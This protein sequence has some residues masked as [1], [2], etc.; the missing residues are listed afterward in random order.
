MSSSHFN[1]VFPTACQP[2]AGDFAPQCHNTVGCLAVM[3]RWFCVAAA[4]WEAMTGDDDSAPVESVLCSLLAMLD[5]RVVPLV[6]P[7]PR[8]ATL[9]ES[10]PPDQACVPR[11]FLDPVCLACHAPCP[12]QSNPAHAA[13]PTVLGGPAW[14]VLEEGLALLVAVVDH[15]SLGTKELLND[16]VRLSSGVESRLEAWLSLAPGKGATTST[17]AVDPIRL[18]C[19]L[20]DS[21]Y[22][23]STISWR[24]RQACLQ[25]LVVLDIT[26]P[27]V[28]LRG[29]GVRCARLTRRV[30][31]IMREHM[32]LLPLCASVGN[33]V[34]AT[35]LD[36]LWSTVG[37]HTC[38]MQVIARRR[39]GSI[40]WATRQT[41]QALGSGDCV[42]AI[43]LA[44]SLE[45]AIPPLC[46]VLTNTR[47]T[48]KDRQSAARLLCFVAGHDQ[49]LA[50]VIGCHMRA[51]PT[52]ELPALTQQLF[53]GLLRREP[54]AVG[55]DMFGDMARSR[56]GTPRHFG[57]PIVDGHPVIH[58][59]VAAVVLRGLQLILHGESSG[60]RQ[61]LWRT[62]SASLAAMPFPALG[63]FLPIGCMEGA[64]CGG[65]P[66]TWTQAFQQQGWRGN[67]FPPLRAD[68][69]ECCGD[70]VMLADC[71][72]LLAVSISSATPHRSIV[73]CVLPSWYY[74]FEQDT[75]SALVGVL[76]HACDTSLA[77]ALWCCAYRWAGL[78]ETGYLTGAVT[79][80]DLRN[81][82]LMQLAA[83][84]L[85]VLPLD[86]ES[87]TRLQRTCQAMGESEWCPRPPASTAASRDALASGRERA[88]QVV[89]LCLSVALG[90]RRGTAFSQCAVAS[91][92]GSTW[93]RETCLAAATSGL[94]A[95]CTRLVAEIVG[96]C[97]F[98]D[99]CNSVVVLMTSLSNVISLR[100]FAPNDQ[101][102][103]LATIALP[104]GDS[105]A[106]RGVL[107]HPMVYTASMCAMTSVMRA[108]RKASP[109]CEA[110]VQ[111]PVA[112]VWGILQGSTASSMDISTFTDFLHATVLL[113]P[114]NE[115]AQQLHGR[116]STE[117]VS[118]AAAVLAAMCTTPTYA[119]RIA[120]GG[121]CLTHVFSVLKATAACGADRCRGDRLGDGSQAPVACAALAEI[122][123]LHDGYSGL[124]P[125]NELL[126]VTIGSTAVSCIRTWVS[127]AAFLSRVTLCAPNGTTG[128]VLRQL[129]RSCVDNDGRNANS[130]PAALPWSHG[131]HLAELYVCDPTRYE[132]SVQRYSPLT[133]CLQVSPR[134]SNPRQSQ[135]A[136]WS[137]CRG[138]C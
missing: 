27:E 132:S 19:E 57:V 18:L 95:T 106:L 133:V 15:A 80:A 38:D 122:A 119:Y 6:A 16:S 35:C 104:E 50:T 83:N 86:S 73:D 43:E 94:L 13:V 134:G 44:L 129:M 29:G 126:H 40:D 102:C 2:T 97:S 88:L 9:D 109:V 92:H 91:A 114:S 33:G 113:P 100:A 66:R 64:S 51:H 101:R 31:R 11:T 12:G 17:R 54:S 76:R 37:R 41:R 3:E 58:E 10:V 7:C 127:V 45:E 28:S 107:D 137:A 115:R 47:N 125:A 59:T 138:R 20:L 24:L 69:L 70:P 23:A 25:C 116:I 62:G 5:P 111:D 71:L 55:V 72:E 85:A 75:D 30:A 135:H 22:C 68:D 21:P 110:G 103:S 130:T 128:D 61:A 48:A 90:T 117:L 105:Q 49:R 74:D 99:L 87:Y 32:C 46:T 123:S 112:V 79:D 131:E 42:S 56:F 14:P 63:P 1:A 81:L 77:T 89:Q 52:A 120:F 136:V 4:V 36:A 53:V 93:E 108:A 39:L 118:S 98:P 34:V 65:S 60:S 84:V 82:Q 8:R 78:V 96:Q 124:S 26:V 67:Q 121:N